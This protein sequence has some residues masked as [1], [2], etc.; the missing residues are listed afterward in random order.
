MILRIAWC[1]SRTRPST[2]VTRGDH[3]VRATP[4]MAWAI[5]KRVESVLGWVSDVDGRLESVTEGTA[6]K[7]EAE[8][9]RLAA[10]LVGARI[11][12][13]DG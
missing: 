8:W 13:K 9:T 7:A 12:R 6:P 3:V 4:A 1:R 2:L 10:A 11:R 5:G